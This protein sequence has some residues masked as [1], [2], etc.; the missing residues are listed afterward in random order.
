MG[1]TGPNGPRAHFGPRAKGKFWVC[2]GVLA[3]FQVIKPFS[4]LFLMF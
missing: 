2:L 4:L 3:L 1:Q